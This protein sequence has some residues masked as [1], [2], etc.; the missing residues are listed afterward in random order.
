MDYS[1]TLLYQGKSI[2]RPLKAG[3]KNRHATSF[4]TEIDG[5]KHRVWVV[6]EHQG[7]MVNGFVKWGN[8]TIGLPPTKVDRPKSPE[9]KAS[10]PPA[11]DLTVT[12]TIRDDKQEVQTQGF[13]KQSVIRQTAQWWSVFSN[14]CDCVMVGPTEQKSSAPRD[15]K[16]VR[17]H[18]H[19]PSANRELSQC[20]K[21]LPLS[22][23]EE[24]KNPTK[25][26]GVFKGDCKCY[27]SQP[28]LTKPD[29]PYKMELYDYYTE[30]AKA[31]E[32]LAACTA[33]LPKSCFPDATPVTTHGTMTITVKVAGT[34]TTINQQLEVTC[35]SAGDYLMAGEVALGD[36][37][38]VV[39]LETVPV[40]QIKG[41]ITL[42]DLILELPLGMIDPLGGNY[43]G[44]NW[45]NLSSVKL[46][47]VDVKFVGAT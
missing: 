11:N 7:K 32:G 25:Y 39:A 38:V 22:C 13:V 41:S 33:S 9:M 15:Y 4:S 34:L 36:Q 37:A 24:R 31:D 10:W 27:K 6:I 26:W 29:L 46:G 8:L 19:E 35:S 18:D 17:H 16:L 5:V 20:I 42:A 44:A 45:L 12:V 40:E 47:V 1:V 2:V 30:E 23:R 3:R 14:D 21:S 43:Y 28:R